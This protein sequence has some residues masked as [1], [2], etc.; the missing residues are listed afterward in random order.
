MHISRKICRCFHA[1]KCVCAR[2]CVWSSSGGSSGGMC[3]LYFRLL[4]MHGQQLHTRSLKPTNKFMAKELQRA[5]E[6]QKID[7]KKN[8]QN[9]RFLRLSS[10]IRTNKSCVCVCSVYVNGLFVVAPSVC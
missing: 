7:R 1:D 4:R 3:V 10:Q 5:T 2:V 8:G 9:T 6:H